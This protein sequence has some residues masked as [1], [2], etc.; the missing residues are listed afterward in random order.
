MSKLLR[1]SVGA[2]P[3]IRNIS[4]TSKFDENNYL[5]TQILSKLL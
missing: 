1:I 4:V 2:T 5:Y 3:Q